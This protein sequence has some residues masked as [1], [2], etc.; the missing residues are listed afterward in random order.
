MDCY[1]RT[2]IRRIYLSKMVE[3]QSEKGHFNS[4]DLAKTTKRN[5]GTCQ[6]LIRKY[7]KD[8]LIKCTTPYYA[9]N[10]HK[11]AEYMVTR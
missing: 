8:G 9:G 11:F 10:Q 6:N 7:T 2:R 4:A 1:P 5:I 3:I